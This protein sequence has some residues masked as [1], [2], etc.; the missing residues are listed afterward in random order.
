[1]ETVDKTIQQKINSVDDLPAGYEPNLDNKWELLSAA[2]QS[3]STQRKPF[4]YYANRISAIAA[5]LLLIGGSWYILIQKPQPTK[6]RA[7]VKPINAVKVVLN[8]PKVLERVSSFKKSKSKK[9]V[10]PIITA[11]EDLPEEPIIDINA[12][13]PVEEIP[14][15]MV[16]T[17]PAHYAEVD[18]TEP[19]LTNTPPTENVVKAQRFKFKLG[20]SVDNGAQAATSAPQ[21]FSIKTAF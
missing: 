15:I 17:K 12:C 16:V 13:K 18:F 19:I 20:G 9:S 5:M 10:E 6:T 14:K 7:E 8:E 3:N 21:G 11:C 2:I 1:M 4:V